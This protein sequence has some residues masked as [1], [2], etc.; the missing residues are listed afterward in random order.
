MRY[1]LYNGENQLG[2]PYDTLEEAKAGAEP[3]N[4]EPPSTRLFHRDLQELP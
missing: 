2:E 4:L 3:E 1:E